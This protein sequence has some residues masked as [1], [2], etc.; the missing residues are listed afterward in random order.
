M[1]DAEWME[2]ALTEARAAADA[3]EV[4]VGAVVVRDGALIATGRNTPIAGHDPSAHAEINALR[5]AA[6]ALANYR[7]D[8]CTLYVTL[9]PCAMCAGAM[10]H[11]RLARVVYG[12]PDPKTGAAG[13]VI[14]LFAQ[15]R[16]NHQTT[17]QGGV[18][19]EACAGLLQQFFRARREATRAHAQP[20]RDDAVRTPD[21][22]FGAVPDWRWAPR[23]VS[24]LPSL[25][26]WRMH[27]IDEG[28]QDAPMAV[29][30]LHGP[31]QWGWLY[32]H[33]IARLAAWPER[34]RVLVA[35]LIGFGRSD[36]PKREAVHRL[37]WH[38]RVL[39][40]WLDRLEVQR[41]VLLH[42]EGEDA[43]ARLLAATRPQRVV[44]LLAVPT[45]PD[46]R[47]DEAWR[48]PFVDAGHEAGLRAWKPTAVPSDLGPEQAA[49]TARSAMGYFAP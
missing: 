42:P 4:P 24:D 26:G 17:L 23:Y 19:A 32:R 31:G 45:L 15:P 47:A 20:L 9:E 7:L 44:G 18:Q 12:A 25:N 33:L 34:S 6:D 14:D 13:S 37:E 5:A 27:Y 36:K 43:L 28:P 48:A 11:A 49:A 10:L 3:G 21:E 39:G 16:L 41:V 22:R 29:V 35:D 2:H 40:E 38:A 1:T 8:G 46:P 30:A